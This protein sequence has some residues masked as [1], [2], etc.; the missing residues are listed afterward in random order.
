MIVRFAQHTGNIIEFD[1]SWIE[2]QFI[3]T[4]ATKKFSGLL[5]NKTIM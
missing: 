2:N 5:E 3:S 4:L 1:N